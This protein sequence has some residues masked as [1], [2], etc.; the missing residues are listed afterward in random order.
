MA[1]TNTTLAFAVLCLLLVSEIVRRSVHQGVANHGSRRCAS[2]LAKRCNDGCVPP[3][4][5][6]NRDVCACY[7]QMKIHGNRY[8][9]P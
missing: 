1:S 8:M 7:A 3:G 5:A 6:A 4:P 2:R 9:C